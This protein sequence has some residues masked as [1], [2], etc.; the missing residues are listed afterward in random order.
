MNATTD[1]AD[2]AATALRQCGV[3]ALSDDGRSR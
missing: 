2:R 1:L 3:G